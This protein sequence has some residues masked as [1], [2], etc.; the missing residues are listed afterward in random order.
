[1]NIEEMR[2]HIERKINSATLERSPFPHLIVE[3]FFPEAVFEKILEKNPF[4]NNVGTEWISRSAQKKLK[5]ETPYFLRKQINFHRNEEFDASAEDAEFWDGLKNCFLSDEWFEK[6]V[7]N[8]YTE[9]FRLR[10]GDFADNG[11]FFGS[12][13][14]ELFLQRHDPGYFIGPHT[15]IPTRVFTCIFSFA[16]KDG[17]EQ[18]GTEL[19]SHKDPLVRCWG[20]DHYSP[21]DF[22]VEKVAPY[23][24]NNFLLFFKTR[25]S[26]HSVPAIDDSVPNQR[27]GMQFQ[28]YEPEGGLFKDLSAPGLMLNNHHKAGKLKRILE[29]IRSWQ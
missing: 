23:K 18:F 21:D 27:Y 16:D 22:L 7:F 12:F 8:K 10:F 13:R 14:K 15:D 9:Y 25:H 29:L 3:N 5:T 6:L 17:F 11:K 26:F 20:C 19:C 4:K 24:P 1:M 28:F 2:D